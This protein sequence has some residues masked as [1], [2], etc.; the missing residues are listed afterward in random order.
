MSY[1]KAL[2]GTVCTLATCDNQR[3]AIQSE[4]HTITPI[5][6][7]LVHTNAKAARD[8]LHINPPL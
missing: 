8:L 2:A 6:F 1:R 4:Q 7:I 3:F 5:E